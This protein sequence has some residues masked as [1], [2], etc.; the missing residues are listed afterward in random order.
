MMMSLGKILVSVFL[1]LS[2]RVAMG[3]VA[4]EAPEQGV[5]WQKVRSKVFVQPGGGF[6]VTQG[7]LYVGL[8]PSVGYRLRPKLSVGAGPI[9]NYYKILGTDF[10]FQDWGG[11]AFL[12]QR[13]GNQLFLQAEYEQLNREFPILLP[14]GGIG[15]ERDWVP[16]MLVGGGLFQPVGMRSG[17]ILAIFYNFLWDA[18]LSASNSPFVTRVG[19]IF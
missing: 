14:N 7:V 15:S 11:S 10:S 4:E 9:Y 5:D 17:F 3:Q 13:I 2:C 6:L 12:R 19:F 18:D 16:G 8:N 1:V